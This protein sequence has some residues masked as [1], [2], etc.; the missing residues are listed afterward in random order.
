MNYKVI[1]G[2]G[3][4]ITVKATEFYASDNIV[5]FKD[6]A[7]IVARVYLKALNGVFLTNNICGAHMEE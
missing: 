4:S 3:D 1:F 6:G 5:Y 2:N 7:D